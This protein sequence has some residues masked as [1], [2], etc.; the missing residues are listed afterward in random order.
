[1]GIKDI[2]Q[3]HFEL[4]PHQKL[5]GTNYEAVKNFRA[6]LAADPRLTPDD[7]MAIEGWG[8]DGGWSQKLEAALHVSNEIGY[9]PLPSGNIRYVEAVLKK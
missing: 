6:E 2:L 7:V 3:K 9:Q 1:M 4:G 8:Q 5:R